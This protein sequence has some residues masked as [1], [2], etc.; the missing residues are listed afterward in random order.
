MS[1]K[2]YVTEQDIAQALLTATAQ[3]ANE[4]Q[5]PESQ[6]LYAASA[7]YLNNLIAPSVER[8]LETLRELIRQILA[9]S[10]VP[11]YLVR[12]ARS[13]VDP[14][15]FPKHSSERSKPCHSGFSE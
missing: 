8:E 15:F 9:V 5:T 3:V 14:Q 6:K 13:I 12:R 1:S 11:D 4:G 10:N 7:R 2:L